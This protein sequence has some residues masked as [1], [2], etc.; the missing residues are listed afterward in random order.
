M[1]VDP[2]LY[3]YIAKEETYPDGSAI[4]EEGSRDNAVYVVLEGRVKIR[5]RT[6]NGVLTLD[7]FGVG[8]ILGEMAFL[9]RKEGIRSVTVVATNGPVK[10]GLLD[11]QLLEGD[12]ERLS[13]QLKKILK[14]LMTRVKRT[15]EK[16]CEIACGSST[17][18]NEE[19]KTKVIN[20]RAEAEKRGLVK[21]LDSESKGKQKSA[22][23]SQ[24]EI[25]KENNHSKNE[26]N[27]TNKTHRKTRGQNL[28]QSKSK[29]LSLVSMVA[30]SIT[31]SATLIAILINHFGAVESREVLASS[32]SITRSDIRISDK[33]KSFLQSASKLTSPISFQTIKL[34][35]QKHASITQDAQENGGNYSG[36]ILENSAGIGS[37]LQ[38]E[39]AITR[40]ESPNIQTRFSRS[41]SVRTEEAL[42]IGLP[43]VGEKIPSFPYSIY[44]GSY[45]TLD[46]TRKAVSVYQKKGLSP[47]WVKLDLGAKGT[48]FRVFVGYFQNKEQAEMF[49]RENKL[50][51]AKPRHTKYA[52]LL[53]TYATLEEVDIRRNLLLSLGYCPYVIKGAN[54]KSLLYAGAF[55]QKKRAEKENRHL[56][57]KGIKS[58][59]VER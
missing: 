23:P 2:F 7:T 31:I 58:E 47:Y 1:T 45:K 34:E 12:Y 39:K 46:R 22:S 9:E 13:P 14:T 3:T 25:V 53:G 50:A 51:D 43:G 57:S 40:K 6:K 37:S 36:E 33:E 18:T 8:A 41:A 26:P 49:I 20:L 24:N 56:A 30:L 35:V 38:S 16:V 55:Y 11:M 59:L 4:I 42:G 29:K 32:N 28:F 15:T 27:R 54:G 52:N 21:S 10:L 19:R 48:W 44:L 17:E 5:K